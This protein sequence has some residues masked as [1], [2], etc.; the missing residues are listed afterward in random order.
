MRARRSLDPRRRD[1][2]AVAALAEILA[3]QAVAVAGR[4]AAGRVA[5]R[6]LLAGQQEVGVDGLE[7][8]VAAAVAAAAAA[9][10]TLTT[11]RQG[12][13]RDP[14]AELLEATHVLPPAA[15]A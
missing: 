8:V 4:A 15:A 10:D 5:V 7:A 2:P 14:V 3:E 12:M 11:P 13:I 1:R 6:R 9:A